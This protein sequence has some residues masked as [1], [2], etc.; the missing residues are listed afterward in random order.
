MLI[1]GDP[2]KECLKVRAT[3]QNSSYLNPSTIFGGALRFDSKEAANKTF[4]SSFKQH[5]DN[6]FQTSDAYDSTAK[7]SFTNNNFHRNS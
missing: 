6:A 4:K 3:T 1:L 2:A 5:A 7:L